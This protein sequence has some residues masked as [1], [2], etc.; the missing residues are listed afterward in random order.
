MVDYTHTHTH[1]HTKDSCSDQK[2]LTF[3]LGMLKEDKPI[4]NTDYVGIRYTIKSKYFGKFEA[5]L[6]SN[7]NT[8]FNCQNN[9]KCLEKIDQE[10]CNKI[11]F[12]EDVDEL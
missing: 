4:K 6:T 10:L 2:M 3:N 9:N 8:K 11:N 5:N 7:M 1:T 12:Y